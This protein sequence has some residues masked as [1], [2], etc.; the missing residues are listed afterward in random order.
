MAEIFIYL[1]ETG[2][3]DW[4]PTAD[5]PYFGF[6]SAVIG[7]GH[8]AALHS[9]TQLRASLDPKHANV[10]EGFHANNDRG[11]TRALVYERIANMDVSFHSTF[12]AKGNAYPY[13]QKRSKLWF[14]KYALFT[15]LRA[16]I[17]TVTSPRDEVYVIAAHLELAAK[18]QAVWAALEDVCAQ[19]SGTRTVQP[20]IWLS[21][22]SPG[23]QIADYGLWARQ[24]LLLK[25][26]LAE[27]IREPMRA[28]FKPWAAP[29]TEFPWGL[30]K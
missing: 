18:R 3:P 12:F 15:H 19:V 2:V 17:P 26:A 9:I 8:A 28:K 29:V 24:R 25:G 10:K 22:S 5:S 30:A 14:Y 4:S 27:H 20:H 7:E 6:G 1:D 21:A 23:L 11:Q 16:L 13:V